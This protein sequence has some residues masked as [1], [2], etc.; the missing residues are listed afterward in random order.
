MLRVLA[1]L[2]TPPAGGTLGAGQD[3]V[4]HTARP[5]AQSMPLIKNHAS[6]AIDGFH[7]GE[8]SVGDLY[9]ALDTEDMLIIGDPAKCRQKMARYADLGVHALMCGVQ[10]GDLS[11]ESIMRSIR[12][13]GDEVIPHLDKQ[14][15]TVA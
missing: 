11:K 10:F 5:I 7:K 12:L 1:A 9:D 14:T 2:F 3:F 13:L 6:E 4:A 8:V 15:A